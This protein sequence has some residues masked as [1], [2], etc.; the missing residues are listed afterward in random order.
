MSRYGP[1]DDINGLEYS[2]GAGGMC[3]CARDVFVDFALRVLLRFFTDGACFAAACDDDDEDAG[4]AVLVARRD[5]CDND[6][7]VVVL[8]A[9]RDASCEDDDVSTCNALRV[10]ERVR[11]IFSRS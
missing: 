11:S 6:A 5:G 8:V 10:A 4:A 2:N 9:R 3:D 1:Y 7:D